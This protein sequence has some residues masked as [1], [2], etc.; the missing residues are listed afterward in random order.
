MNRLEEN[1]VNAILDFIATDATL[2]E[3][4][5]VPWDTEQEAQALPRIAVK[6]TQGEE[7][8]YGV[9]VYAL[10]TIIMLRYRAKDALKGELSRRLEDLLQNSGMLDDVLTNDHFHCFGRS[11]GIS[12]NDGADA[13]GRRVAMMSFDIIGFDKDRFPHE[14]VLGD[15]EG[16]IDMGGGVLIDLG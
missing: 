15:D 16:P 2:M 4:K 12:T 5:A 13:E 14:E 3:L 6:M 10:S 11:T 8:V 7:M 9:G 1:A